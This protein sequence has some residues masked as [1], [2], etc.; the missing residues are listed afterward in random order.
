M[1]RTLKDY[2]GKRNF[3]RT[4][5]PEA[6]NAQPTSTAPRFV[7][8][9]H[10][11]RRLHYDLRLEHDGVLL[12][13]ATPKGLSDD[14][15][16]R[17]LAVRTEDHP[18]AYAGFEGV[19]PKGEY[20]AGS[21]LIWDRGGMRWLTDP[22]AGL[23]AGKLEFELR[24]E[25]ARGAYHM[26]RLKPKAGEK[27]ENWLVFKASDAFAGLGATAVET[28]SVSGRSLRDIAAQAEAATP[29]PPAFT[30]PML[31]TA[32]PEPPVGEGWLHE[33]KYDGY[34]LQAACDRDA[35]RLYTRT[36]LDWTSRFQGIADALA[37]LAFEGA[38][39]DAEAI[40]F[41]QDG[42]PSF[43]ALQ[44]ALTRGGRR[45]IALF[46][47]DLLVEGHDDLR[48][49]P[50][51]ERKKRLHRLLKRAPPEEPIRYSDHVAG[52]GGDML[53][54]MCA[55]GIE[56]V[57]SKRA[58]RPYR[59]GRSSDWIKVKCGRRADFV[60][61]GYTPSKRGRSFASLLIGEWDGARLT[62]RGRVGA[63][64]DTAALEALDKRLRALRTVENPFDQL[65]TGVAREAVFVRPQISIEVAMTELTAAGHVRHGVY[66]GEREDL[67]MPKTQI[68]ATPATPPRAPSI[69]LTN[70]ERILFPESG[71]TKRALADYLS[72]VAPRMAPYVTQRPISLVRCPQ[73]RAGACFFQK[74]ATPG[75][76]KSFG[77]VDIAESDGETRKYLV[78]ENAEAIV[79]CAQV[80]AIEIHPWGA[81][82]DALDKPD[83]LVIDLD[84]DEGLPFSVVKAAAFDVRDLLEHAGMRTF[85]LLTGGKGVHLVAPLRRAHAWPIVSAFAAG[86]AEKLASL[87]PDRF[88]D[89]AVKAKRVG[90]IFVDHLRNR[91]GATAVAP[92]SPRARPGA[93]VAAPI[94]WDLLSAFESANAIT[95]PVMLTRIRDKDDPW[96]DYAG[97]GQT[98]SKRTFDALGIA[99][100][101]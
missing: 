4:P 69:R 99:R 92:Y 31:A 3:T 93:P 45:G 54:A 87:A 26:V 94:S 78:L 8:Q 63:G 27:A 91:R 14:P 22:S 40:A 82:S 70:P 5:E 11:A 7:I 90:K 72:A 81:R 83:R 6:R 89:T 2:A 98:L 36:G 73:G 20:G 16:V 55:R 96:A 33:M 47:F 95:I 52:S 15:K 34:R 68:V 59:S 17:R 77:S 100:P 53:A 58:D 43:S 13:W 62:Y 12:S 101:Q 57:V 24:G 48:A 64:F 23:K 75:F 67:P 37:A 56:G 88:T 25:R 39:I 10:A 71:L 51:R 30:P 9:M 50:L 32:A 18:L 21:M 86:L 46:C 84:P 42:R 44:D 49:L 74:H 35:V 38:L 29:T 60:I 19:I 28:S 85:P 66:L 1:T 65:P 97:A 61:G 79:G 80:G 41:A 76:P